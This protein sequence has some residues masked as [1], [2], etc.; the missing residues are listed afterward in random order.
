MS[1]Q[2]LFLQ[3]CDDGLVSVLHKVAKHHLVLVVFCQLVNL[4]HHVDESLKLHLSHWLLLYECS[5]YTACNGPITLSDLLI[6]PCEEFSV[7]LSNLI[8]F[9]S[10]VERQRVAVDGRDILEKMWRFCDVIHGFVLEIHFYHGKFPRVLF[11]PHFFDLVHRCL[12]LLWY[13]H[14]SRVFL[15]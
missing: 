6:E 12:H 7:A 4:L 3:L 5:V 8:V 14:L 10:P 2:E 1:S 13:C 15:H 11:L 9:V